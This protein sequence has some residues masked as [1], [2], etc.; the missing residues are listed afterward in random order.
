MV[1]ELLNA[2]KLCDDTIRADRLSCLTGECAKHFGKNISPYQKMAVCTD[3][4]LRL[5]CA[6]NHCQNRISVW[7]ISLQ[8][9][10]GSFETNS[11]LK[12]SCGNQFTFLSHK[13]TS[14]GMHNHKQIL[15]KKRWLSH[16]FWCCCTGRFIRSQI[17]CITFTPKHISHTGGKRLELMH[18]ITPCSLLPSFDFALFKV[19]HYFREVE[20]Y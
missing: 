7:V 3:M 18:R 19:P 1:D 2:R 9:A 12:P 20:G 6:K 13:H 8:T 15:L 10:L 16:T 11:S 4:R 14:W 5:S 17:R